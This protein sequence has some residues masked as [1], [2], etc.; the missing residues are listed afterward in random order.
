MM[1]YVSLEMLFVIT[2]LHTVAELQ[3]FHAQLQLK[4]PLINIQV[5]HRAFA[6][7]LDSVPMALAE[8]SVLQPIETLAT[9]KAPQIKVFMT[10]V[11]SMWEDGQVCWS[12]DK[13]SLFPK[14]KNETDRVG[15]NII[16]ATRCHASVVLIQQMN[17]PMFFLFLSSNDSRLHAY[18]FLDHT[19]FFRMI[20]PVL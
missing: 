5:L 19:W 11:G 20:Q 7:A 9:V 4:L 12:W 15:S 3:K 13:M 10:V 17:G 6:D 8:N 18:F 2:R 1:H 16:S 14:S